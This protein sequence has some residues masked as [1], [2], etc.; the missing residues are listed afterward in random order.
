MKFFPVKIMVICLLLPPILYAG[1]IA[2]LN[3]Y[4]ESF[5]EKKI[6]NVFLSDTEPLF[7]GSI[8][9]QNAVENNIRKFMN[10]DAVI[11]LL[12]LEIEILIITNDGKIIYPYY[13]S[14]GRRFGTD[15]KTHAVEVA[16]KNWEIINRDRKSTRL[17]SSHYS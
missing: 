12:D 11:D 3:C 1:S 4:L 6:E 10:H 16:Q 13:N 15:Y 5:Y 7:N 9:I 8:Q 14:A 17:N 2:F